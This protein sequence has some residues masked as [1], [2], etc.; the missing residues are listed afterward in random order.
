MIVLL[1]KKGILGWLDTVAFLPVTAFEEPAEHGWLRDFE[2]TA[3]PIQERLCV[4]AKRNGCL[5][6]VSLCLSRT[7]LGK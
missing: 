5:R 4:C 1:I 2:Q 6:E 7:C 3:P